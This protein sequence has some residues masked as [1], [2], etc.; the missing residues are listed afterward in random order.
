MPRNYLTPQD[1][2]SSIRDRRLDHLLDQVF[3]SS[4]DVFLKA[5]FEAQSI[6]EDY[7]QSYDLTKEFDKTGFDRQG[8]LVFYIKN[9]TLYILYQR[10]EDDDV[11]ERIIKNY[12]D[13]IDTLREI[14][15]GKLPIALPLK[16]ND[17]D[18]DGHPDSFKTRFRWGGESPREY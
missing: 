16:A 18:A 11:P 1:L 8:S 13:T 17:T 10:I 14:A 3:E 12:N 2:Q 4:D 15:L 5:V 7:L 6:V 9:L